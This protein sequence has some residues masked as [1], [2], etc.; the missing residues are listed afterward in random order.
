VF[1]LTLGHFLARQ[2]HNAIVS[3]KGRIAI[4]SIVTTIARFLGVEPNP[5]HSVFGFEQLDQAAFKKMNFC[6]VEAGCL[7]SIY[8][9]DRR[10]L[11]PN[12]ERATLLHWANLY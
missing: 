7:C 5:E 3:T 12:V 11:F 8:P 2:L 9:R 4:G 10:L 1:R 6:K